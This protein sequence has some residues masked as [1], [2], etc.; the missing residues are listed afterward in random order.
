M[1][2]STALAV[3][4]PTA[5]PVTY[6]LAPPSFAMPRSIADI[7]TLG[8]M[9]VASGFFKDLKS[10]AQA[11]VK[12]IA[13]SA[14]GY[15]AVTALNAFH[16]IEGKITPTASEIGARVKRS[17]KYNYRMKS[18]DDSGCTLEF[19]ERD[20]NGWMSLGESTFTK[21]DAVTAGVAGKQVWRSYFRNMAFS[22]ALTNGVR[23]FCPDLFGGPVYTPEELGAPVE[24]RDGEMVVI[25]GEVVP[26][27][28]K[29]APVPTAAELRALYAD[30]RAVDPSLPE[31]LKSW[32][33][34]N[35]P[36]YT[37]SDEGFRAV[38]AALRALLA[39]GAGKPPPAPAEHPQPAPAAQPSGTTQNAPESP[40]TARN[41]PMTDTTRRH[42][43]GALNRIG[44]SAKADRLAFAA[45]RGFAVASYS[46]L[47]E[48]QAQILAE[49]A[50]NQARCPA[51]GTI[52][53]TQ[54]QPGCPEG[55]TL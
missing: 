46:E 39:N 23:W 3:A 4:Q 10:E 8:K 2:D 17:G 40:E 43:M 29:A 22:R 41:A 5:Q 24:I 50:T 36:E 15:D 9:M 48:E 32:V 1:T 26:E 55:D 37:P 25:E 12:I 7:Q 54:H 6:A 20:G 49:D 47:T 33:A 18:L 35:V 14:L 53:H 27:A 45:Q 42:L 19:L 28:P 30:C 31:G 52:D 16:I 34:A 51:C 44:L 11:C 13:G 21:Q 38:D